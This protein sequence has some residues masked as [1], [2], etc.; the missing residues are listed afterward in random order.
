MRTRPVPGAGERGTHVRLGLARSI[1]RRMDHP[2]HAAAAAQDDAVR[3]A[4]NSIEQFG[5]TD[6]SGTVPLPVST[7]KRF[8]HARSAPPGA[9]PALERAGQPPSAARPRTRSSR[10]PPRAI[11]VQPAATRTEASSQPAS[12]TSTM[13]ADLGLRSR[14]ARDGD[15]NISSHRYDQC[16]PP[17]SRG[18]A[19]REFCSSR[20]APQSEQTSKSSTSGVQAGFTQAR[21]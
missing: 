5:V 8:T 20:R 1:D 12:T 16:A 3:V 21:P 17:R 9:R 11:V 6:H 15:L 19:T 2:A 13:D 10:R 18:Y 4:V 14:T 7:D